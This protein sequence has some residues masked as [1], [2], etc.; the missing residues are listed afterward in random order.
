MTYNLLILILLRKR[1]KS[2]H[3]GSS[4]GVR[5]PEGSGRD[6][7]EGVKP[8]T[9]RCGASPKLQ[10]RVAYEYICVN[11]KVR[12]VWGIVC[13]KSFEGKFQFAKSTQTGVKDSNSDGLFCAR[14][15][16]PAPAIAR[17]MRMA[18][19]MGR[20]NA[21]RLSGIFMR[22]EGD[23]LALRARG[24]EV[25]N[26]LGLRSPR[27]APPHLGHPASASRQSRLILNGVHSE[28]PTL[29]DRQHLRA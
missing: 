20:V 7:V 18:A 3:S 1:S 24:R 17:A 28:G 4:R 8:R 26:F 6:R 22:G 16:E 12:N 9:M 27:L 15:R 23:A 11:K 14:K 29:W 25:R 10:G 5:S 19:M 21:G 13:G 2:G